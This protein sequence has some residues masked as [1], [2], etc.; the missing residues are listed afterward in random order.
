MGPCMISGLYS[1][2]CHIDKRDMFKHDGKFHFY[3]T[4]IFFYKGSPC[5]VL[6]KR[7][8]F[9]HYPRLQPVHSSI[10][11]R[12]VHYILHNFSLAKTFQDHHQVELLKLVSMTVSG[13][14]R[15]ELYSIAAWAPLHFFFPAPVPPLPALQPPLS[16]FEA[17]NF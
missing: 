1:T 15:L 10:H 8:H 14:L 3:R 5:F 7:N 9:T 12:S 17:S 11:S 4:M 2:S 6:T 13:L 16:C